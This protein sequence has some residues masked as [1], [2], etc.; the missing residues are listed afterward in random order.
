[1]AGITIAIK[2]AAIAKSSPQLSKLGML[3]PTKIPTAEAIFHVK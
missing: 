3:L 2:V 1:M